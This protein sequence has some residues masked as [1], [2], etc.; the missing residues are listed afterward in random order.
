MK[1]V[2]AMYDVFSRSKFWF[3]LSIG[4][5]CILALMSVATTFTLSRQCSIALAIFSFLVQIGA[6]IFRNL[7]DTKFDLAEQ[8]RRSLMLSDG[9]GMNPSPM[10]W[11]RLAREA[12]KSNF[13]PSPAGN[14]YYES[15]TVAGPQRLAEILREASF[16]TSSLSKMAGTVFFIV[17]AVALALSVISLGFVA[18]SSKDSSEINAFAAAILQLMAF[19]ASSD[20]LS[21]AI[22]FR[23]MHLETEKICDRCD[24]LLKTTPTESDAL[25]ALNDY[26]CA[27][28]SA[29]PIP[30]WIYNSKRDFLNELWAKSHTQAPDRKRE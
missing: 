28:V 9:M 1:L 17:S 30:D 8:M 22:K 16:W 11:A 15:K 23:K 7:A 4:S 24:G 26:N 20:F 2:D 25:L 19:W 6:F 12:G 10:E 13:T 14:Q 18:L 29:P 21:L 3:R 5:T 27:V